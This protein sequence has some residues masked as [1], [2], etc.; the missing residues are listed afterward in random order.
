LADSAVDSGA[1]DGGE[2]AGGGWLA[3]G[4]LAAQPKLNMQQTRRR[5]R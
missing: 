4:R 3:A 5:A 1:A 2:G